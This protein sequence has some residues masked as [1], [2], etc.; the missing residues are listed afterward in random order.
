VTATEA[1]PDHDRPITAVEREIIGLLALRAGRDRDELAHELCEA[2]CDLPVEPRE[3][4][5][6][7][8]ELERR[9]AIVLPIDKALLPWL[10]YVGDLARLI[11]ARIAEAELAATR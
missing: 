6:I 11:E 1:P 5:P 4:I 2:A 9:F 7:L 3:L 10:G 8:P